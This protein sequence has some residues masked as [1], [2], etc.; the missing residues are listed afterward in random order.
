MLAVWRDWSE[1]S[2]SL[3][4]PRL[5]SRLSSSS[6]PPAT[7]PSCHQTPGHWCI[8]HLEAYLSAAVWISTILTVSARPSPRYFA[9]YSGY[10]RDQSPLSS[11]DPGTANIESLE[12]GNCFL[13][14]NTTTLLICPASSLHIHQDIILHHC[15]SL[16]PLS[17]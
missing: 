2:T 17:L 14:P 16:L 5:M 9:R 3:T 1:A 8:A 13:P 11:P 4:G 6:R 15:I 10:P 12:S 7:W